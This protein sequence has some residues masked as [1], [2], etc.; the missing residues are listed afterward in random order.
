MH[1]I[2]KEYIEVLYAAIE[3]LAKDTKDRDEMERI[4]GMVS[5]AYAEGLKKLLTNW[6]RILYGSYFFFAI[7]ACS[8]IER[9]VYV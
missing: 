6:S 3:L 1:R 4:N 9:M 5:M 7:F 8:F 2:A